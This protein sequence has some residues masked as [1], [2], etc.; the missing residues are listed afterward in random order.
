MKKKLLSV[1]LAG[2]MVA[3]TLSGCGSTTKE[4]EAVTE[5]ATEAV[6]E[7][8]TEAE[9][10]EVT[11]AATEAETEEVTEAATEAET[12]EVTE[13]AEE[14]EEETEA[15]ETEEVTEAAEETEAETEAAESEEAEE[16]TDYTLKEG[17]LMV[18]MEIGYPPMEYFD[19]DGATPIGFDVEVA[20][21][22][23]D[24]LGLELE[25]VDTAWDGIFAG[26]TTDKYD[27][28]ISSVSYTEDRNDTYLLSSAYVANAPVIVVPN[29]SE[30]AD[31]MDLEGMSVAVQM[32]TTADYLI[33]EYVADGL[34]TDLRQYE[35]V[36]NAFDEIKAGRVD[37]VCTDS[38]VASY[39][40]GDDASDYKTVWQS[41]E[42][43]PIVICMK[44]GND[45]LAEMI[46]EGMAELFE[47]GTMAELAVKYFG[48]ED[49]I[50]GLAE[51][52]GVE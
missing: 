49:V 35:K 21:A 27:C 30:I 14:T 31:I 29:D 48:T 43:E 10:E 37:A 12:E 5:A 34:D 41:E 25:L 42:K 39:Y 24:V 15:A 33:Q 3:A 6:T 40:L 52:F 38:V 44:Q 11:E 46:N 50:E 47:N 7:A 1:V 2:M 32:E 23:A 20:T 8:A 22:L 13:A 4:T 45:A 16:V 28:I 36:I 19:E 17:V 51:G 26:V 18:G 9:T